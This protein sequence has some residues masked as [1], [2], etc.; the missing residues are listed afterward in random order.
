MAERRCTAV[1]VW[2]EIRP[3]G[4]R[5][6]CVYLAGHPGEHA[7]EPELIQGADPGPRHPEETR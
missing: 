5:I 1:Q 4:A 2:P 7:G 3:H 6:A